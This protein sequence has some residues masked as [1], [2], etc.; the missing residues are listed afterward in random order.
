VR[1]REVVSRSGSCDQDR[2]GGSDRV[3]ERLWAALLL[4][5]AVKSP[6]LGQAR[7]RG[8]RGR[9]DWVERERMPWRTQWRGRGHESE[10]RE[11]RTAGRRSR[12]D[13][14]NSGEAFRP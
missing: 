6:E 3:G 11:G 9:R 5:A 12:A 8:F 14:R 13:R 4:S 10:G 1:V 7:A 2:T